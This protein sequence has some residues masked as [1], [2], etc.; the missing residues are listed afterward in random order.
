M[1]VPDFSPGEILTAAAVDAIGL[2]RVT[3]CTVTS[4]GGTAATASNGVITVG[5]NNTSIT[6]NNAFSSDYDNYRIIYS[7]GA[8]STDITLSLKLGSSTTG[9]YSIVNYATYA[10]ATTG[11]SAGDNNAAQWTYIGY[12]GTNY[13]QI[14]TDLIGPNLA[15]WTTYGNASWAG[16][17]I[18]GDSNGVHQVATAYTS[19]TVGVNT[20]NLTGGQIRVYGYRK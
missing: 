12:A 3:T 19:F 5:T 13:T 6:V 16:T 17:T 11:L 15:K 2:W 18:G 8:G 1:P 4:V 20:G 10:A 14:A 9:Y 7:G